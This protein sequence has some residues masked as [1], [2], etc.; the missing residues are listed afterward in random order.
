MLS[1][2][3][4]KSRE[5]TRAYRDGGALFLEAEG[6]RIR[7]APQTECCVR[8]S[9]TEG[10]S[11]G[12]GQGSH[13]NTAGSDCAWSW[14]ET[15]RAVV[16]E[17]GRIRL[18]VSREEGAIRY[19]KRDGSLLLMEQAYD[20]KRTEAYQSFRTVVDDRTEV[21]EVETPDGVKRRLRGAD[22]VFDRMLCRTRLRLAFSE[23]EHL[24]GLGQA[25]E[26]AGDLRHTVQYLH[27][28]NLKI[29][30]PFLLSDRGYG[31]LLST[32]GTAVFSDTQFGS[33]LY[34]EADEYLDYFFIEGKPVEAV[35]EFRR[36]SGRA[37]MLPK[38]AFGYIQSQERYETAQELVDTVQE[39]RK[40]KLGIDAIVLDWQYWKE[41]MWG[42]KEFDRDRFPDPAAMTRLLHA[43]NVRLLISVWPN[44]TAGSGNYR[45]FAESGK[46]L[47]GSEIYDAF[48]QEARDLYW[49]QLERELFRAGTDGWWCDSSEPLTPEWERIVKPEPGEMYHAYRET[50]ADFMPAERANAYGMYHAQ[51]VYEGQRACTEEKRVVNLT[52]SGW[53][54]SQKYGTI[55]WSGDTCARWE[56]LRSQVV[57]GLQFC[58]SGMPYW[59]LDIGAFFVK[60]GEQWFWDGHY[61]GG[62]AD[63]AY[64]ELYVRWFQYGVFLPV[65]RS[66]GTDCRR[67]PWNFGEETQPFYEAIKASIALRYRLIAYIYSLA[68]EV[69]REHGTMMRPLVFDFP[70]DKRAAGIMDT[71]LF[72][73]SLLICPVTESMYPDGQVREETIGNRK[74][75]RRVYL[76]AGTQWYDFYTEEKYEG[77]QEIIAEAGIDRIPV[78]VRA[79]AV[80]PL[81]EAGESTAQMEGGGITLQ[82]YAGADGGFTLYEDAGDGY[83]YE[84]GEYCLTELSYQDE[85]REV[86]WE[87]TGMERF[88]RG[89]FRVRIVE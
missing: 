7:L 81:M 25:E 9:Y 34:T 65:F 62:A 70:E 21:E 30:I 1:V 52:R 11:F 57:A 68:G 40:R 77:G 64:R 15:E 48:D 89:A 45:E 44:M 8:I 83:G 27:Q 20:S 36:L 26:G 38:W 16:L 79:G 53:A 72:G 87:T 76:P 85:K 73:P 54:G 67:E 50:A 33:Y 14:R 28:A 17:T 84:R 42:Q 82:A 2:W 4:R 37:A 6:G 43:Q 69:W 59:T 51:G 63:P 41:G 74:S 5:I 35:R 13:L 32:Q 86:T 58:A 88:R 47:P 31:L 78:Y 75:R 18:R 61:D 39:F 49:K 80:L 10:D 55:L 66:H 46:L 29:A 3:H 23:D 71:Y 56:T 24:Y 22:K 12:E 19:E 60:S